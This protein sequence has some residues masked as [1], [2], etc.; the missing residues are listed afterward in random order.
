[1]PRQG[2]QAQQQVA[3]VGGVFKHFAGGGIFQKVDFDKMRKC[4]AP[5]IAYQR[6]FSDL[7]RTRDQ[8]RL[9]TVSGKKGVDFLC[10]S[11]L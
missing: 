3:A 10:G 6:S 9:P 2:G 1:M 8:Q 4:L 5:K 7:T 11:A